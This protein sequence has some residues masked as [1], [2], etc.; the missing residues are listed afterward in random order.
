MA[1]KQK[2]QS[3][4][5]G[6]SAHK[7]ALKKASHGSSHNYGSPH[8]Q[9]RDWNAKDMKKAA[10]GQHSGKSLNELIAMRKNVAKGSNEYNKIQN[11]IN[12]Q[13]GSSK[14]YDVGPDV[15]KTD[16]KGRV[17]SE[18]TTDLR[19]ATDTV[20]YDRKGRKRKEVDQMNRSTYDAA[21]QTGRS[22]LGMQT[23][24]R[25]YKKDGTQ[26]RKIKTRYSMGTD[27]KKDDKRTVTTMGKRK[28]KFKTV[29]PSAGKRGT[30]EKT[31]H[32]TKGR[33]AGTSKTTVRQKGKLFGKGG[34]L[35]KK[36]VDVDYS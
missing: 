34:L 3:I 2:D 15:T 36:K 6:T 13:M 14:R 10:Q 26:K 18:S 5:A 30:V 25:K 11:A 20:K 23:T 27:T 29:D 17:R 8:Q 9:G 16:K 4:I 12:K 24:T 31:K 35:G 1:Y 7:S 19:G 22:G 28:Q 32:Y 33:K 21:T